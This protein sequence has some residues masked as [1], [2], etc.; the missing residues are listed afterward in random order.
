MEIALAT[1]VV[2]VLWIASEV[3]LV[4]MK[5]SGGG[6]ATRDKSTLRLLWRAI[7]LGVVGG[8]LLSRQ[9]F[10]SLPVPAAPVQL[11]G[12]FLILAG[13]ALRW[14]AILS[15]KQFFTVD[16]AIGKDH[17]IVKKGLYA[18]IRHP[19]Y[20]GTLLSFFGL[21]I[22]FMNILSLLV[23]IVPITAAFLRRIRVEEAVLLE[24]FGEEYRAYMASTRR[25]I[26]GVY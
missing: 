15:L 20:A 14:I 7:G 5:H 18:V 17:T 10:G 11:T 19:A 4:R 12:L 9:P 22:F 16:V 24:A 21:G 1:V 26:P 25:L 3:M 2:S 6:D 13:L 8:I 23:V